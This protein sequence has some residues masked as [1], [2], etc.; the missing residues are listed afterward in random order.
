MSLDI[1]NLFPHKYSKFLEGIIGFF[2]ETLSLLSLEVL[3]E[4]VFCSK[5]HGWR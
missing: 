1:K 4:S 2:R 5:C 3:C